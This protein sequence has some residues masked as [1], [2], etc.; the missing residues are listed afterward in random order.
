MRV[1]L[2]FFSIWNNSVFMAFGSNSVCSLNRFFVSVFCHDKYDGSLAE[3]TWRRL[4]KAPRQIQP[5]QRGVGAAP[6][7]VQPCQSGVEAA[8]GPVQRC[9]RGGG[10]APWCVQLGCWNGFPVRPAMPA[11]CR[12]SSVV[13]PAVPSGRWSG[14]LVCPAVPE[15][16]HV[17]SRGHRLRHPKPAL[18]KVLTS[19]WLGKT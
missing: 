7:P 19:S 16:R 18:G 13:C 14:A 2:F 12:S 8:P 9:Q 15:G 4:C 6:W 3:G 10:A 1:F 5:C 17:Q 11:A